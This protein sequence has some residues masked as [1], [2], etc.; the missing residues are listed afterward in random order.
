MNATIK[1]G[2]K[3]Q[4]VDVEKME[5]NVNSAEESAQ[6]AYHVLCQKD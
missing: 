1:S 6:T 2:L 4:R 5:Y 3:L